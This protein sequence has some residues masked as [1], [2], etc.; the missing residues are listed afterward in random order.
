MKARPSSAFHV[1]GIGGE[2]PLE[3]EGR[4][5][6]AA[7]RV[8]RSQRPVRS[9]RIAPAAMSAIAMPGTGGVDLIEALRERGI[10]APV[11]LMSERFPHAEEAVSDAFVLLK[12]FGPD[13]LGQA[14]EGVLAVSAEQ[15]AVAR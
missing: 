1:E 9:A 14:I 2:D 10:F 6:A 7:R 3:Q 13:Q 4:H 12:P 15:G 8:S 11:V 5:D